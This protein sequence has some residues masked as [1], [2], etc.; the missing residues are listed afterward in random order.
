[1]GRLTTT[2]FSLLTLNSSNFEKTDELNEVLGEF[3]ENDYALL[4]SVA[5]GLSDR[6]AL[7]A[8]LRVVHHG[9]EDYN[10]TGVGAD[11]GAQL[12]VT[13]GLTIGASAINLGGPSL[14][15]R[16]REET[17][18]TELR[19]G[20]ALR[21]LN[22]AGLISTEITHR[23]GPGT[24]ARAGGEVWL[25]SRFALRLGYYDEYAAGGFGYR[26]LHGW[27]LDYGASDH[28][29]GLVHRFA[30]SYRFGGFHATSRANP[31]VF[32][33]AGRQPITKFELNART[34]SATSDWQLVISNKADAV[35]R[36]FGGQNS[37]PA[38]VL[39]DGKDAS[40]LPL[41][42][43]VYGYQLIVHDDEGREVVGQRRD[44]EIS[45]GGPDISVPV[46]VE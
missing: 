26:F 12:R 6:I 33:P 25:L 10:A 43:G 9:I 4:F 11:V 40:G 18:A 45:T 34:K 14:T 30:L 36:T 2:G 20:V 42:D 21:L 37:P 13:E 44:V 17:F 5:H 19:G 23:D 38:H 8:N 24:L 29:L 3:S 27:Q 32:S 41:P 46:Q 35:V 1:M 7:G 15:L 22:G 16:E 28:E 39:W 31:E